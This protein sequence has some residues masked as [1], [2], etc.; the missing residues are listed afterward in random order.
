MWMLICEVM[1]TM[2]PEILSQFKKWCDKSERCKAD[3][4][5]RAHRLGISSEVSK[6]LLAELENGGWIDEQRYAKAFVHDKSTLAKWSEK[7]IRL[8]L[9]TKGIPHAF[10][11]SAIE[12]EYVLDET[13]EI[14]R[15]IE[16]KLKTSKHSDARK[17]YASIFR[18]LMNK[19]FSGEK[20]LEAL[21]IHKDEFESI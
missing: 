14:K 21:R 7:R 12:E 8:M 11:Q 2:S 10:V 20:V 18:F 1:S 15:W 6:R 4:L 17:R 5:I 13:L 9:K 16:T 3:V 19:G